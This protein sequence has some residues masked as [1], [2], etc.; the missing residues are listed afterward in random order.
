MHVSSFE[1]IREA[2]GLIGSYGGGRSLKVSVSPRAV[3]SATLVRDIRF[4][5]K[6]LVYAV[7]P[8]NSRILLRTNISNSAILALINSSKGSTLC[9]I[10]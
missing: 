6:F 8:I 1:T 10:L 3:R 2:R 4:L 9:D 7:V 5:Y